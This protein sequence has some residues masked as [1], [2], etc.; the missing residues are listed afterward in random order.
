MSDE[1]KLTFS[2]KVIDE[3]IK[4]LEKQDLSGA[5]SQLYS[6]GMMQKLNETQTKILTLRKQIEVLQSQ[7][8]R[9]ENDLQQLISTAEI[10]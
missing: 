3:L 7:I 2:Q 1:N 6:S 10:N 8:D 5:L 4:K 9:Y